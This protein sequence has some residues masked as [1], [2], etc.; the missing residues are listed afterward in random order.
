MIST[1]ELIARLVTEN[2][3]QIHDPLR[4]ADVLDVISLYFPNPET[5]SICLDTARMIRLSAEQQ[6][7]L[8]RLTPSP[9]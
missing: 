2:I 4:R 3:A 6:L 1:N 7:S 5:R 9:K 8:P